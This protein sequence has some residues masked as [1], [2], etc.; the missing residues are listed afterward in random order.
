[1]RIFLCVHPN[2]NSES[3]HPGR[4][5][6]DLLWF[7]DRLKRKR[8]MKTIIRGLY[9]QLKFVVDRPGIAQQ[10]PKINIFVVPNFVF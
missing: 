5:M 2:K 10:R 4:D 8:G 3:A 9:T 6:G 1:M 7:V